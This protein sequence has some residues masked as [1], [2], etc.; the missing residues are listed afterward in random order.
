M[1]IKNQYPLQSTTVASQGDGLDSVTVLSS[2][3]Q[4]NVII[5]FHHRKFAIVQ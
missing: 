5:P 2:A 3:P 1:V 4:G